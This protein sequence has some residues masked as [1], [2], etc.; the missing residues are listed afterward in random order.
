MAC[1]GDE[2]RPGGA[3]AGRYLGH[4]GAYKY[5]EYAYNDRIEQLW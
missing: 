3:G 1:V 2:D 5:A 4:S